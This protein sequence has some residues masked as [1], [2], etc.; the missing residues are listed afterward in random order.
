MISTWLHLQKLNLDADIPLAIFA[1]LVRC[2]PQLQD[3]KISL[4]VELGNNEWLNEV[5]QDDACNCSLTNLCIVMIDPWSESVIDS[6]NI[7][8]FFIKVVPNLLA[9]EICSHFGR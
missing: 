3:L 7:A 1:D 5:M 9:I 2:C 8:D 6:A 4:D